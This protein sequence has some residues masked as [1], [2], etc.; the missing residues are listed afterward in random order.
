MVSQGA[1]NLAVVQEGIQNNPCRSRRQQTLIQYFRSHYD[2]KIILVA[3]GKWPCLMPQLGIPFRKT[4]SE[5]NVAAWQQ[6]R[7]GPLSWVEWIIRGSDDQVDEVMR[8]YPSAFNDFDLVE[9]EQFPGE[10]SMEIYR[11]RTR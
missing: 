5:P 9:R 6:L 10:G 11:R 2:G 8:A 4:L 3:A 1:Q 7:K